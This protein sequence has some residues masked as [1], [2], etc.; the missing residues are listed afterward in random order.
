[1]NYPCN[2]IFCAVTTRTLSVLLL[3]C[4]KVAERAKRREHLRV[5]EVRV[6]SAGVWQHEHA[7]AVDE[8]GLLAERGGACAQPTGP[9]IAFH[10]RKQRPIQRHADERHDGRAIASN[11]SVE[12]CPAVQIFARLEI[13]DSGTRTRDEVGHAQAPLWKSIVVEVTHRFR[14][15]T[16]FGEQLPESIRVSGEMMPGDCRPDAR[17]DANKQDADAWLD[18]ISQP[19]MGPR[20]GRW[21]R[22]AG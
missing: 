14:R 17:I 15:E 3:L 21:A 8:I 6:P 10:D 1:M 4:N 20:L 22:Y 13:V 19:Q 16:G 2:T 9:L 11:L 7:R 18:A 12:C 5:P